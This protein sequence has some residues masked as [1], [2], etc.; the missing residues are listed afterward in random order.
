MVS[1][2]GSMSVPLVSLIGW[3]FVPD[4]ATRRLLAIFYRFLRAPPPQPNTRTYHQHY[5]ATFAFVVLSYLLYNLISSARAMPPNFYQILGVRPDVDEP[6][7]KAA[8]RHFV[9]WNHPDRPGVGSNGEEL[10]ILVRDVYEALKDPVVRFAYDRFGPDALLW[11]HC[12]TTREYIR[13]G[14]IR[15]SGYHIVVGVALVFWSLVGSNSPVSFWRFTLY[16]ALCTAE[17]SLVLSPTPSSL[18]PSILQFPRASTY[19]THTVLHTLFPQRITHQ[20]IL[21]L[22]QLFLFLSI[23]L[24]RVVPVLLSA[25]SPAFQRISPQEHRQLAERLAGLSTIVDRETTIMMNTVLHSVAS[26]AE[27]HENLSSLA[28][29]RPFELP[30]QPPLVPITSSASP[31]SFNSDAYLPETPTIRA[32]QTLMKEMEELIIEAN[33]KQEDGPLR[34]VWEAA[35]KRGRAQENLAQNMSEV[36]GKKSVFWDD[37]DVQVMNKVGEEGRIGMPSPVSRS[38]TVGPIKLPSSTRHSQPT[39]GRV[40]RI[41]C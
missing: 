22:H 39:G 24:S 9:K 12:S 16:A 13:T 34:S 26:P 17:I 32:L 41:S 6:G 2:S 31:S 30:N 3:S 29:P 15:S 28:R 10:F 1:L 23:A 27:E 37:D 11:T 25:F 33:I 19:T 21:F 5:A 8:F 7:L 40:R 35:V 14:L 4:F 36:E 18:S 38:P 20:H